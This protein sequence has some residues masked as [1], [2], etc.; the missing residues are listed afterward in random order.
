MDAK[1][2]RY[3]N[4][5]TPP[6]TNTPTNSEPIELWWTKIAI[7]IL[8]A[9]YLGSKTENKVRKKADWDA[10]EF[11]GKT[12]VLRVN[13]LG[14]IMTD[15]KTVI[16]WEGQSPTVQKYGRFYTLRVV[17]WLAI[18]FNALCHL[19]GYQYNIASLIEHGSLFT[20]YRGSDRDLE[21]YKKWPS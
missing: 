4:F 9:H 10:Q 14:K 7:P 17:R 2:G 3:A 18:V 8:N 6:Y 16:L 21:H 11:G 15:L 1:R 13:E 20:E 12:F 19:G 5:K